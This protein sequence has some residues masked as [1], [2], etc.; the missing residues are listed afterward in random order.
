L[1]RREI[2]GICVKA[3]A[4]GGL[5]PQL[6]QGEHGQGIQVTPQTARALRTVRGLSGEE[7]GSAR[8]GEKERMRNVT[9]CLDAHILFSHGTGLHVVRVS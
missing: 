4:V 1:G 7:L 5:V 2:S 8:V 6:R 3:C 9:Q